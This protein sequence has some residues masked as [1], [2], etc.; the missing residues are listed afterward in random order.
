VHL[1][2]FPITYVWRRFQVVL[3]NRRPAR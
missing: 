2:A 1:V 3:W